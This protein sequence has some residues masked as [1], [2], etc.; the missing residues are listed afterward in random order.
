MAAARRL[1][2]IVFTD[3]V[4]Y[5]AL[6]QQDEPAALGLLEEQDRVVRG[7]LQIHRGRKVKSMGD[8]LLL[9]FPDALDAVEC[10]V[11][12]QQKVHERNAAKGGHP[13]QIRVGIHLGDVQQLGLQQRER[14]QRHDQ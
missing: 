2:A 6:S 5:T 3:I 10:A 4:G 9:E 11:E 1:A 14:D 7:L 13:L 8:G 12:L